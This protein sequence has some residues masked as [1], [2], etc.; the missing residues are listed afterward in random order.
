MLIILG[1]PATGKSTLAK[2]ILDAKQT[3]SIQTQHFDDK[4]ELVQICLS[5]GTVGVD[6]E[7]DEFGIVSWVSEKFL[8]KRVAALASRI[9]KSL[10]QLDAVIVEFCGLNYSKE[11]RTIVQLLPINCRRIVLLRESLEVVLARNRNRAGKKGHERMIPDDFILSYYKSREKNESAVS[12]EAILINS[13]SNFT[14]LALE[15]AN[16]LFDGLNRDQCS[17]CI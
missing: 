13:K 6:F 14:T 2:N 1:G 4:N 15:L 10:K 16:W 12:T 3:H 9:E 17:E 5:N 8:A 7:V 11:L